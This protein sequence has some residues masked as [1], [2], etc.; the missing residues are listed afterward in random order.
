MPDIFDRP[1]LHAHEPERSSATSRGLSLDAFRSEVVRRLPPIQRSDVESR[2][3]AAYAEIP[4]WASNVRAR[5]EVAVEQVLEALSAT[6]P[7]PPSPSAT[8]LSTP[9]YDRPV[10]SELVHS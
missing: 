2:I 9:I 10:D 5:Q 4:T 6:D 1:T 7:P 3:R 8:G